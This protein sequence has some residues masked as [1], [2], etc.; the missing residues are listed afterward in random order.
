MDLYEETIVGSGVEERVRDAYTFGVERAKAIRALKAH[1]RTLRAM[2]AT[3]LYL[4]GSTARNRAK[5]GS[6][7]DIFIE[8]DPKSN[9]SLVELVEI[10]QFLTDELDTRVDVATRDSLH[11]MLRKGIEQSA[12]RVF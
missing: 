9:F 10:Q 1:R 8:Y 7:V 4:F 6:D 11:P 5:R 3:A 2:G 12:V